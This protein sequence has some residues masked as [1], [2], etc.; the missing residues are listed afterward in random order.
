[1]NRPLKSTVAKALVLICSTLT[2]APSALAAP[3]EAAGCPN[4]NP[5]LAIS[6]GANASEFQK[7]AARVILQGD[8]TIDQGVLHLAADEVI[9]EYM[10]GDTRDIGS[11][12]RVN[13]LRALGTVK[14]VCENDR[15]HGGEAVYN[16]A[17]R[18][19]KLTRNVL[20]VRGDNI[21]KGETLF[22]NLDTGHMTIEGGGTSLNDAVAGE[23]PANQDTRIKAVFTPARPQEATRPAAEP[24]AEPVA[25]PAEEPLPEAT[26]SKTPDTEKPGAETSET[27]ETETALETKEE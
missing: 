25:E 7:D 15:A 10:Q 17:A 26:D 5:D 9:I 16:V 1:M 18:T 21:L 14:I 3:G 24:A 6:V 8:V 23:Q 20:L 27:P 13:S 22:I 2:A 4:V 12:G 11:Q 19:I